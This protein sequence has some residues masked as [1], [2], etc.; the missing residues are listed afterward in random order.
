M[1]PNLEPET[2]IDET[3][4]W[5]SIGDLMSA[6]LMI[7]ALI[8][9]VTLLQL[10]EKIE[11]EQ[12]SRVVIIQALEQK[13]TEKGI[14]AEVDPTTGDISILQ[15]VLFDLNDAQLRPAGIALLNDFVPIYG[16]VI[17]SNP[18]IAEQIQY[19]VV[20]GHTSSDGY[21]SSNMRLS[22]ARANAVADL[23]YGSRFE[24]KE[25]LV[26]KLLVSGRGEAEADQSQ[27]NPNDRKVRFR[28]QFKTDRFLRW[29]DDQVGKR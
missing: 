23:I 12:N 1:N 11:E 24:N 14:N 19:V 6:L 26:A 20:E 13:L 22:T 25:E 7:F 16:S 2:E 29:F 21:R 5:L 17:F 15:S 3:G 8:L 4:T 9:I 27:P 28:F 18:D 10:T